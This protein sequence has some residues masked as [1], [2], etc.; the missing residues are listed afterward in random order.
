MKQSVEVI[1][2]DLGGVLVELGEEPIPSEWLPNKD[3]FNLSDWFSSETAISFEKGLICAQTFAETF[4]TDLKIEASSENILKHFTE[5]PI[6]LFP[7]VQE[8]LETL[9]SKYKLAV[10]S[11]TNELHWPRIIEEFNIESYFDKFFASHQIKMAK[12]SLEIFQHVINELQVEPEKIL[13]LDDNLKNI[14]ASKMLG[15]NSHQAI[16]IKQVCLTLTNMGIID[17]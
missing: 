1:L 3:R 13:F 14:E 16:G 8:L 10:L 12:P 7:G 17:A 4:R 9:G 15:I 2:F 5:W 6:G 11:N